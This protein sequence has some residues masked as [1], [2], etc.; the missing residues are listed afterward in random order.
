MPLEVMHLEVHSTIYEAYSTNE[1][2]SNQ[3]SRSN[4]SSQDIKGTKE[5]VGTLG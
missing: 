1:L 5:L 2:E 4:H 3:A